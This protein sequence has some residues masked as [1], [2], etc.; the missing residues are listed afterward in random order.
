MEK[1]HETGKPRKVKLKRLGPTFWL[2]CHSSWGGGG[3]G[4]G[5]DDG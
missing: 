4:G 3:G 5:G 1:W 2:P